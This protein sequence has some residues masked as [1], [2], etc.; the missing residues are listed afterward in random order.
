MEPD[1]MTDAYLHRRQAEAAKYIRAA[2]GT[3]PLADQLVKD[4]MKREEDLHKSAEQKRYAYTKPTEPEL[5]NP[6]H[7]GKAD[8]GKLRWTLLP[9]SSVVSIL[10]ILEYGARKY[11]K[12][13]WRT[14][15][16]AKAR[17]S[18][19]LMRHFVAWLEGEKV[20]PESGYSHLAHVGCNALF[21]LWF[22][23]EGQ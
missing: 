6:K 11:S 16:S 7:D 9:W 4:A 20:D 5:L 18:D 23:K 2:Y 15:P 12:D 3:G 19:A 21:L 14:V 8:T 13:G 1:E 17:Y 22:E 10:E